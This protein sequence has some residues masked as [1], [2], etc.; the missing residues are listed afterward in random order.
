M[1][2][3]QGLPIQLICPTKPYNNHNFQTDGASQYF[4]VTLIIGAL[5]NFGLLSAVACFVFVSGQALQE[6]SYL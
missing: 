5:T 6:L 2:N 1:V 4:G 3:R